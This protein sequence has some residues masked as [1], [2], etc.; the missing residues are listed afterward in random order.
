VG[1]P[2]SRRARLFALPAESPET[3]ALQRE[4]EERLV[5]ERLYEPEKRPFWPH[6]TVARVRP[7]GRGGRAPRRVA[8]P[9]GGLPSDLRRPFLGVRVTLYRS[10]LRPQGAQYTPLAQ[11]ELSQDGQR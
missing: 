4:L 9:P 11:V 2:S 5:A 10:N 7:E 3:V 6:L 8:D 1:R